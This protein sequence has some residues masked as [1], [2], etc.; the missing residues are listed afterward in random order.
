[1]VEHRSPKPT[2]ACSNRVSPAILLYTPL[3]GVLFLYANVVLYVKAPFVLPQHRRY[4][5]VYKVL[6]LY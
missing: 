2:V 6:R 1:M 3:S 5:V 4:M